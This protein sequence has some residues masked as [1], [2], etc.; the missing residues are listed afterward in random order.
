MEKPIKADIK[1]IREDIFFI[2][3]QL[4]IIIDLIKL[5]EINEDFVIVNKNKMSQSKLY[6]DK[7]WG[8]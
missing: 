5:K 6:I 3:N 8:L 1:I 7:G 2:K 4:K